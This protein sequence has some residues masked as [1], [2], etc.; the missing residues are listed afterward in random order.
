MTVPIPDVQYVAG[1]IA[2]GAVVAGRATSYGRTKAYVKAVNAN[3]FNPAGLNV[4][5]MSTK[6]MMEE[7]GCGE[8]AL[9]LPP[10]ETFEDID[11]VA[12]AEPVDEN[13]STVK[14]HPDDPRMRRIRALEGYV[15][16]LSFDVPPP[17][18]S[19]D[20][21]LKRMGDAHV[22]W[23]ARRQQKSLT[24]KR[25]KAVTKDLEKQQKSEVER[26]KGEQEVARLT[27][28]LAG[29]QSGKQGDKI[30]KQIDKERSRLEEQ[31]EKRQEDTD[32]KLRKT[33]EK[34]AK[35]ARKI[36]WVVVNVWNGEDDDGEL[37]MVSSNTSTI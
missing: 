11:E 20:N 32:K 31:A 1:G 24:K 29:A 28:E 8:S 25:D 16:P 17:E 2:I 14:T 30:Q 4:S 33:D 36:R 3:L 18:A 34:E 26:V 5:I 7:L 27:R 21:F 23:L 15:M 6:K 22:S 10:L 35:I 19:R 37:S 12:L 9:H 13:Q